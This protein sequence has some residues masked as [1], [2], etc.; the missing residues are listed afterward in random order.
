MSS[1]AQPSVLHCVDMVLDARDSAVVEECLAAL[2]LVYSCWRAVESDTAIFH[3]YAESQAEA[4]QLRAKATEAL[5]SWLPLLR[6]GFPEMALGTLRREDW[7][8]SWKRYFHTFRASPRLVVKPT[9][10]EYRPGADEIVVEIDPGMCFG[11][12]HHGTTRACLEFIDHVSDL[13]G[14]VGFLD[15]GCGSGILTIAAA[16]L[17][18]AP[19]AAFD[20]DAQAVGV[21]RDNLQAAGVTDARVFCADVAEC[22]PGR[23]YRVVV[24]NMLSSVL[25]AHSRRIAS[26]PD[27]SGGQAFLI[28]SGILAEQYA[29]AQ[30]CYA[31]HGWCE[32]RRR[33]IG[34]WTSGCFTTR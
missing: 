1:P 34:E 8:E 26:F 11:T 25:L 10:E 17:G 4:E 21:A 14:P 30:A 15:V 33:T 29:E 3:V 16:K 22:E 6:H 27:R 18:F 5:Q 9:W 7:A 32:L 12:G 20:H 2:A 31:E 13:V 23:G 28:L 24:A 19:L